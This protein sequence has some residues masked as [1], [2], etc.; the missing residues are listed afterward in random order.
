MKAI[1]SGKNKHIINKHHQPR[2]YGQSTV[3]S[4]DRFAQEKVAIHRFNEDQS[5]VV[6]V[7]AKVKY[8]QLKSKNRDTLLRMRQG[9]A[10]K[11]ILLK[12]PEVHMD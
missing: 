6:V 3:N 11:G 9:K 10:D 2:I 5:Q 8:N 4:K 7:Q 1:Q 12:E